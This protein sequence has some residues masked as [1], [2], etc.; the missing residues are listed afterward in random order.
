MGVKALCER[1]DFGENFQFLRNAWPSAEQDVDDFLEV[2]QP[3][4]QFQVSWIEDQGALAEAAAVFVVNVE[5][6]D[7]TLGAR[8]ENLVE[9]QRD[10]AGLADAGG[11][12]HREMLVEHFLDIDIGRDR[13]VL[14]QRADVDLVD[15]FRRV[16]RA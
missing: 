3:E 6:E 2:E 14:L 16:D 8:L 13:R 7:A 15:T 11:A 1:N 5:Q 10:A 9:Q 4:R 12:E